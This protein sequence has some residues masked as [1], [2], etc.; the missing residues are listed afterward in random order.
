MSNS[1]TESEAFSSSNKHE[2]Y[3]LR[4]AA[5]SSEV[6]MLAIQILDFSR[7]AKTDDDFLEWKK[8]LDRYEILLN[9]FF[10]K[11]PNSTDSYMCLLRALYISRASTRSLTE[12]AVTVP[13][14]RTSQD[15]LDYL[16]LSYFGQFVGDIE[17]FS[18]LNR[19]LSRNP[20]ND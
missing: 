1:F 2:M 16:T 14:M 11:Y 13:N 7:S 3:T 6:T 15:Y 9:K 20:K 8:L 17:G 12:N 4:M 10:K 5:D 19:N 18:S